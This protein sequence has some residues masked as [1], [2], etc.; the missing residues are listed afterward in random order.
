MNNSVKASSFHFSRLLCVHWWNPNVNDNSY[1]LGLSWGIDK[2]IHVLALRVLTWGTRSV[3]LCLL[4]AKSGAVTG[5]STLGSSHGSVLSLIMKNSH[6]G[7]APFPRPVWTLKE[8]SARPS[9]LSLI[10]AKLLL[11]VL[12][13]FVESG[14]FWMTRLSD[15]TEKLKK[16]S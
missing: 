5:S 10:S 8:V 6:F 14:T 1:L 3:S 13:V 11:A 4:L 15:W 16:L 7:P 12:A 9:H 2:W